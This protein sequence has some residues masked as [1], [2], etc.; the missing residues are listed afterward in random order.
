M[1]AGIDI[2]FDMRTDAEGRDPDA[3][4]PTLLR[5]HQTL[6]S[7]PLPSGRPFSLSPRRTKG[8]SNYLLHESDLGRFELTSD[9]VLPTFTRRPDM[10]AIVAQV[11]PA[12][13]AAFNSITYTIGGMI[14]WPGNRI[15]GKWTINQAR[16]CNGR[17]ADR[18]DLTIECVRQHYEGKRSNPLADV[19]ARYSDF[20]SLFG[21][22]AGYVDFWLL[23]DLVDEGGRVKQFLP[24]DEF[25][26]S[27]IPS[28]FEDYLLYRDRTIEFVNAR[29]RRIQ[30]LGL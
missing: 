3:S 16:G 27:P 28:T 25:R 29:N 11:P 20:F 8:R 22:F 4:S 18:F 7:K 10:Q 15:D 1:E 13:I 23:N 19:L 14:L 9:S 21:D 24:S 17:I 12:D 2:T 26:L 5:Y 30:A 6:W